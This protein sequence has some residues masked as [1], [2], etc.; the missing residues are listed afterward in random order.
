V[1]EPLRRLVCLADWVDPVRLT[2]RC[3]RRV[4][5]GRSPGVG[6]SIDDFFGAAPPLVTS[7]PSRSP[8]VDLRLAEPVPQR[9]RVR[10]RGEHPSTVDDLEDRVALWQG[11]HPKTVK[12]LSSLGIRVLPNSYV[13]TRSVTVHMTEPV[14]RAPVERL[15]PGPESLK[16]SF[17]E[18]S[19]TSE[20]DG[21]YVA[22]A[23]T[24]APANGAVCATRP[25]DP[26]PFRPR[27]A[28]QTRPGRGELQTAQPVAL[29]GG[30]LDPGRDCCLALVIHPALA[31][32]PGRPCVA[33]NERLLR[34]LAI[35]P[36]AEFANSCVRDRQRA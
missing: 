16:P 28:S 12:V 17:V 5:A 36:T 23:T 34:S 26:H 4:A 8:S 14:K 31:S 1:V 19:L 25:A 18:R 3:L 11:V 13:P 30:F 32:V 7:Q 27:E 20:E 21:L 24:D 10:S 2:P 33:R 22:E 35:C 29:A 15:T 9:L 6:N